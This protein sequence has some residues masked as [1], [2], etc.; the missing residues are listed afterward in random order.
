MYEGLVQNM[1]KELLGFIIVFALLT[2]W[3]QIIYLKG[4]KT[5]KKETKA[6]T[7]LK[8]KAES[9]ANKK[10]SEIEKMDAHSVA[11]SSVKSDAL[12]RDKERLKREFGERADSITEEFFRK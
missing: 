4:K 1:I 8:E 10:E 3:I 2:L 5:V 9:A 11:S 12:Q 6:E 7:V